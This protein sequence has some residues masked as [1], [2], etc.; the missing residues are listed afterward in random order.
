MDASANTGAAAQVESG[1][2]RPAPAG[3]T[4][5]AAPQSYTP[6][7]LADRILQDRAALQ[8]ERKQVTVLFADVKGSMELAEQVDPEQWHKILDGFFRILTDGVHRY[9]GTVNQYTGDGIMALFGA[10]IA[11][12]DHARR[13]CMAALYVRDAVR[14]YANELRL[15]HGLNFSARMGINSGE[16][17]V[18]AIGDDLRMD[19]TAQGHCVG[20]AQRME[21]LA[22]PGTIYLTGNTAD[23][24]RDY[25]ELE[26]LGKT[27]LKGARGKIGVY[28][29][30]RVDAARRRIDVSRTR[31]FTKFVGRGEEFRVLERAL[32]R[33]ADGKQAE[34]VIVA[35]AGVGKS[36]L[37]HEFAEYARDRWTARIVFGQCAAHA[38]NVPLL[39]FTEFFRQY[40]G[41]GP[42]E[43]VE[44]ARAKTEAVAEALGVGYRRDVI[45]H[46]MD[47]CGYPDPENPVSSN[48]ESER[49]RIVTEVTTAAR[50]ARKLAKEPAVIIWEDMHWVDPATEQVLHDIFLSDE[51][52]ESPTLS[53]YNYRP[54]Y[55]LPWIEDGDTEVIKLGELDGEAVSELLLDLV[56]PGLATGPLADT[57]AERSGGNPFFIEEIVQTF[58]ESR[59]LTGVRGSY[60][61]RDADARTEIPQNVQP[62][63][64]ARIDRL[65]S[66]AKQV[67]QAASAIDRTFS[68]DLLREIAEIAR[69]DLDDALRTLVSGQFL[70]ETAPY[71]DVEY[72]FKHPLTQEVAYGSLLSDRKRSLHA[73]IAAA[74][75]RRFRQD[76]GDKAALVAYHYEFAGDM[77]SASLWHAKAGEWAM[78][79]DTEASLRHWHRCE[80]LT[81]EI[82]RSDSSD[83]VPAR[84][85]LRGIVAICFLNTRMGKFSDEDRAR[86]AHGVELARR[87]GDKEIEA[88]LV[89]ALGTYDMSHGNAEEAEERAEQGVRI[90]QE[91]GAPQVL[92]S[93]MCRRLL[94][95][96]WVNRDPDYLGKICEET[97]AASERYPGV[98]SFGPSVDPRTFAIG[99]RSTAHLGN[100]R[101][102]ESLKDADTALELNAGQV[103]QEIPIWVNARKAEAFVLAYR[104]NEAFEACNDSLA[105]AEIVDLPYWYGICY[106]FTGGVLTTIGR[107]DEAEERVRSLLELVR[108]G[109]SAPVFRSGALMQMSRISA[110]RGDT[111]AAL[112][113][114]EECVEAEKLWFIR[115]AGPIYYARALLMARGRSA[116]TEI[117]AACRKG[118]AELTKTRNVSESYPLRHLGAQIARALGEEA[119]ARAELAAL[120]DDYERLGSGWAAVI[121]EEIE[122]PVDL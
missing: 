51:S 45:A 120:A 5:E 72:T 118:F 13:A 109:R 23:L 111:E 119:K 64:A 38:R 9:E 83:A 19:Y 65:G 90:A 56:G 17:I 82:L 66:T 69:G 30:K 41:L 55:E 92:L 121:R 6:K 94:A 100:G 58:V 42:N 110:A 88:E 99:F 107:L 54:E 85:N 12:E 8:G 10:P 40:N 62:I 81:A 73:N 16:V 106:G 24:V 47:F 112:R 1:E 87:L 18:G 108:T 63:L 31:G 102:A 7:H 59:A 101:I 32:E 43:T 27:K 28:R 71:P 15:E 22:E 74:L 25:A 36:R 114:A 11:H 50:K 84:L 113:F 115:F 49:R 67:L 34:V 93:T 53:I 86:V 96:G 75:V 76:P 57:I 80:E 60:R 4:R 39:P 52:R 20:L 33:A 70:Y 46:V 89:S 97:I 35:E 116:R 26:D 91:S 14:G 29:L 44:S 3:A 105:A 95:C 77:R 21:S 2:A 68:L 78:P 117:E 104:P 98:R 103:N 79:R 48:S 122:N 37:C 61:L